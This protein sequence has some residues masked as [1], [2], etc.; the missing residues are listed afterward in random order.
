MLYHDSP[1][2]KN[3]L[4]ELRHRFVRDI[5]ESARGNETVGRE[6]FFFLR[7]NS[8][9]SIF[10]LRQ[11]TLALVDSLDE[12]WRISSPHSKN[13]LLDIIF[14]AARFEPESL[15]AKVKTLINLQSQ[16]ELPDGILGR[17]TRFIIAS[18][19]G[20]VDFDTVFIAQRAQEFI[21]SAHGL[22]PLDVALVPEMFSYLSIA[23][24]LQADDTFIAANNHR[25]LNVLAD[26]F[27]IHQ[28]PRWEAGVLA[29]RAETAWISD[30]CSEYNDVNVRIL[31]SLYSLIG[32]VSP[33]VAY[34]NFDN[35]ISLT[36]NFA[37][38]NPSTVLVT[39]IV[40]TW[41][42]LCI[43][44]SHR[45]FASDESYSLV[46]LIAGYIGCESALEKSLIK[47]F[48]QISDL[49]AKTRTSGTI[50]IELAHL[51]Y[52]R[53][54]LLTD[55]GVYDTEPLSSALQHCQ[56]A[57]KYCENSRWTIVEE[58]WRLKQIADLQNKLN[59]QVD[60]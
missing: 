28:Y 35:V 1:A 38:Q 20:Q 22:G 36:R 23:F 45:R 39:P 7:N 57:V 60:S 52:E 21:E 25:T 37:S 13:L 8:R 50:H 33:K 18:E 3:T 4:D 43:A 46:N 48:M 44:A 58:L 41:A 59:E 53:Y 31:Q 24:S 19:F 54:L 29:S 12:A 42:K 15:Y 16:T 17:M 55:L 47:P 26:N 34:D 27:F 30:R 5:L 32:S 40:D 56:S 2:P 9:D 11:A 49:V 14:A 51:K 6:L 10:D